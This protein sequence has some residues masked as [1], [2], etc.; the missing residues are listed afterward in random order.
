MPGKPDTISAESMQI[1]VF[2][3]AMLLLADCTG[4]SS[5]RM[6]AWAALTDCQHCVKFAYIILEQAGAKQSD[7][8]PLHDHL[9]FARSAVSSLLSCFARRLDGRP[10]WAPAALKICTAVLCCDC[11][12][13]GDDST[14]CS[15]GLLPSIWATL[16][17]GMV[18]LAEHKHCNS[19]MRLDVLPVDPRLHGK[20]RQPAVLFAFQP[21]AQT[22]VTCKLLQV[23]R[24]LAACQPQRRAVQ[25]RQTEPVCRSSSSPDPSLAQKHIWL[26]ALH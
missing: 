19:T 9:H 11:Q 6:T 21:H 25:C 16:P 3:D 13:S 20:P 7:G 8:T 5:T 15:A 1:P 14:S 23:H 22:C 10:S 17:A 18:R 12:A 26:S 2:R 4:R 24:M